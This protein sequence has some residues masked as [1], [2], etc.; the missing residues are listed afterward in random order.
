MS[1]LT[2]AFI[3]QDQYRTGQLQLRFPIG[4]ALFSLRPRATGNSGYREQA[5]SR[6]FSGLPDTP[7]WDPSVSA[8]NVLDGG[9]LIGRIYLDMHP[10]DGK[11]KWFSSSPVVPGIKGRQMPEGTLICNFSGGKPGDPGLMQYDDV[12][13]FFHEFG[14]LMHDILGGRLQWSGEAGFAT[15]ETL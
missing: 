2:D 14:H 15:E 12:V 4:A 7:V 13:V 1:L 9:K 3:G 11:D 10:R 5:V 8:L 6:V